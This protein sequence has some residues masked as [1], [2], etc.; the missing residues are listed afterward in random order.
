[1]DQPSNGKA[2]LTLFTKDPCQLCDEL[3]VELEP[4]Y[5]KLELTSV[6][7]TAPGNERWRKLYQYEIPVL[8]LEGHYLCKHRLNKQVLKQRLQQLEQHWSQSQSSS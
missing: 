7:I 4:F 2:R 6:D 1:M 8:F 3:K 5:N